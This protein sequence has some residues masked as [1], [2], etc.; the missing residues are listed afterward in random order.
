MR[1]VIKHI[2]REKLEVSE[3]DFYNN[4]IHENEQNRKRVWN[5]S[6]FIKNKKD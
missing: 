3:E 2:G 4:K 5:E 6:N 1:Q